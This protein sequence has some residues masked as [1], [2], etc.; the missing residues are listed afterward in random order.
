MQIGGAH[1]FA[2]CRLPISCL[3]VH[4]SV[5]YFFHLI[6]L[7][8]MSSFFAESRRFLVVGASAN[9]AK[10]GYKVLKWYVDRGLPATPINPT[11]NE[12]LGQRC[13]G[14]VADAIASFPE[15]ATV[16]VSVITPIAVTLETV[17]KLRP[18]AVKAIWF[19]PGSFDSEVIAFCEK[20]LGL[21]R[22][23][24]LIYDDC[25]LVSGDLLRSRL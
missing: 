2:I 7:I 13:F 16:S 15:K 1:P 21:V 14:S 24:S 10:F 20:N 23:E 11:S 22:G 8:R 12:I 18:Q 9:P 6:T 4:S 5:A 17:K 3:Y 19:Q 25:I